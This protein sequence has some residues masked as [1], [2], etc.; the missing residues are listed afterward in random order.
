M[1]GDLH[2]HSTFSDGSVKAEMLP[3]YA[4]RAGLTSLAISDHDSLLSVRYAHQNPVICSGSTDC[5]TPL[6]MG[7][8][9][10]CFGVYVGEG[11]HTREE[12]VELASIGPGMKAAMSV[13]LN[14]FK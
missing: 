10:A 4:A 2:T 5:N 8:P 13:L 6:S 12:W 11:A 14:W 1:P 7:V 9:S 3:F